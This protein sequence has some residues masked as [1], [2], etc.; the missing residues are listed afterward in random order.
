MKTITTALWFLVL[1]AMAAV[2]LDAAEGAG[3]PAGGAEIRIDAQRLKAF[4]GGAPFLEY[5]HGGPGLFKSY[6]AG[7]SLDGGKIQPLRDAPHDHLHHHALMLAF[8]VDGVEFWGVE[9]GSCGRMAHQGFADTGVRE[10]GRITFT[11]TLSW[12][13]P[14]PQGQEG[15]VLL[16]EV[17]R[18]AT[19]PAVSGGPQMV[20]WDS[21]FRAPQG[22]GKATLTGRE[23][24]GLG[25]RFVVPMDQGG[26]FLNADGGAGVAGTNQKR[27]RWCSYAA[28]PEPGVKVTL[29]M[30]DD[31]KNPRSPA[32]WFTMDSGFAYMTLTMGLDAEPYVLAEDKT[33]RVHY[34]VALF[35]GEADAQ[36]IEAAYRE[37]FGGK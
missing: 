10:D 33:L 3:Q 2:R 29:A 18:I 24:H 21:V 26:R 22:S 27:S 32:D 7:L 31:P 6:I 30:F 8:N 11:E 17:R 20:D 16:Q 19:R 25:V 12:K 9:D 28:S 13:A 4:S 14:A 5:R 23:Y 15:K 1:A 37:W 35:K 34:G 36:V